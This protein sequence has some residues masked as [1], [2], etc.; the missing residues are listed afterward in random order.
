MICFDKKGVE[1]KY[2]YILM[3][4]FVTSNINAEVLK[5]WSERL[6]KLS[7]K[8][9]AIVDKKS[10]ERAFSGKYVDTDSDGTYRCKVCNSPLYKSDDKFKSHCGWPSFDDAIDGA[11]KK[12]KDRDGHRVEIVCAK[13]NAHL[14]HLF[15]GEGYTAKNRRYCVNSLSLNFEKATKH[16]NKKAY[17]AGGCFWGVEYYLEKLKGV[18]SVVSGFMGG[19]VA[20]PSYRQVVTTKTGHLE[21]VEVTYDPSLISYRELAKSIF[22]IHDPTQQDGQGPDIGEQYKSAIFVSDAK[23]RKTIDE[24]ISILTKKGYKVATKVLDKKNF[25]SAEDYHQ[26]YYKKHN[27]EPYCHVRVKRF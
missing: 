20:D 1:M 4:L 14:G 12:Q 21:T 17:F 25:Y 13:C 19:K 16:T 23:E 3:I 11:I 8:E 26:D 6:N 22:E 10:T 24:L 9:V 27:K 15:E 5:P 7:I 2:I 18:K